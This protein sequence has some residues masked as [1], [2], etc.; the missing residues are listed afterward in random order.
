MTPV[1]VD[2]AAQSLFAPFPL[3]IFMSSTIDK[4]LFCEDLGMPEESTKYLSYDSPID[5]FRRRIYEY[6]TKIEVHKGDT[7]DSSMKL[8]VQRIEEL[9]EKYPNKKGLI[10]INSKDEIKKIIADIDPE[11]KKRLTYR[12]YQ[13]EAD[14]KTSSE[15]KELEKFNEE[16]LQEHKEK[17]NS[18]LISPSMWEGVNLKNDLGRFCIIAKSPFAPGSTALAKKKTKLR[19]D[20]KDWKETKD[21]FKLIQGFGRCTRGVKDHSTTFLIEP[22]CQKMLGWIKNYKNNHKDYK[23]GW[24]DDAIRQYN[25]D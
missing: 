20:N 18:V 5:Q 8:I 25:P 17:E 15:R 9:M 7:F 22:G 6:Y 12:D 24:F 23:I 3:V 2:I 1:Q 21:F 13:G 16:L 11:L 10:L 19:G 14:A 4:K